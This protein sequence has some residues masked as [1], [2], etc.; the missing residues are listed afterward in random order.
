[1]FDL[2]NITEEYLSNKHLPRLQEFQCPD[3]ITVERFLREEAYNL[4]ERNLVRTRLFFDE[5]Q[6]IIG[7][8]S[9]FN[10]TIKMNRQKRL[11][12]DIS[13]PDGVKEIPAIRLHYLG[14]DIRFRKKGFGAYLMASVLY[15]CAKIAKITGCSLITVESTEKARDFYKKF[16]FIYICPVR[17]YYLMALNTKP[18][19]EELDK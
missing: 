19:I 2:G 18:L 3:E 15:N 13:L 10:D 17:Q 12:M 1:M 7:F 5:N 8:Y 11:Q 16:D 14:V 4:M 6:N 9:L